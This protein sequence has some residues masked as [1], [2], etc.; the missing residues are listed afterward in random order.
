MLSREEAKEIVNT[1]IKDEH[2]ARMNYDAS[3]IKEALKV[4]TAETNLEHYNIDLIHDLLYTGLFTTCE[5]Y[6]IPC[7]ANDTDETLYNIYE[8]MNKPYEQPKI[9]ISKFEY[10]VLQAIPYDDWTLRSSDITSSLLDKEYF[11]GYVESET[12]AHYLNRVEVEED[13]WVH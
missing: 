9:K 7:C 10:D 8:W 1:L 2:E 5:K 12:I 4:L 11:K 13:D 6:K 3:E